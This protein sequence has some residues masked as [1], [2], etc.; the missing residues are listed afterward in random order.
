MTSMQYLMLNG[1]FI[2]LDAQAMRLDH[3][4]ALLEYMTVQ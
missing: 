2:G 1:L 3:H 4:W